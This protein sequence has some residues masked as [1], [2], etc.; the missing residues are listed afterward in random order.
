MIRN[1]AKK[2]ENIGFLE[3]EF[4]WKEKKVKSIP[5]DGRSRYSNNAGMD[6]GLQGEGGPTE[7][8]HDEDR[9]I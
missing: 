5:P 2:R 1:L 9:K 7:I 6:S 3:S 4:D 8:P